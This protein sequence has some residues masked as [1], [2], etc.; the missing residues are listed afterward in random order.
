MDGMPVGL[1]LVG[2]PFAEGLL[3]RAA[4]AYERETGTAASRRPPPL[5]G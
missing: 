3:L 5:P 1:Q 4:H 2:R